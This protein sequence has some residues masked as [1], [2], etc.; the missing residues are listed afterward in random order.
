MPKCYGGTIHKMT[1]Q[2]RGASR[3]EHIR[4][5]VR[6]HKPWGPSIDDHIRQEVRAGAEVL[7]WDDAEA[8]QYVEAPLTKGLEALQYVEAPLTKGLSVH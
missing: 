8:L 7:R 4:Q 3:C 6:A 5:E 2:G 1:T